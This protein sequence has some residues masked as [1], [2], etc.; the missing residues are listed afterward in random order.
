MTLIDEVGMNSHVQQIFS[1]AL[2]RPV[3]PGD[4]VELPIDL[5]LTHDVLGPP[6]FQI[7][8]KMDRAV[9][10]PEKVFLT[11]DHFVPAS[12]LEQAA[13]NAALVRYADAH[14]IK[15]RAFYDGP[16]HQTLA[17]SGLL[18]PG[19]VVVGTDS[20][21]CTAGAFGTFAMGIGCTEMAAVLAQGSTWFRVPHALQVAL[22]G[23]MRPLVMAKDIMLHLLGALGSD[24]ANG[25]SLEYSGPAL[26]HLTMDQRF[27][28]TNMGIEL[29]TMSAICPDDAILRH[30]V[31]GDF[32]PDQLLSEPTESDLVVDLGELEPLCATP[33]RPDNVVSIGSIA[34]SVPVQ[35]AFIG[36]CTGGRIDDFRA[37]ADLLAGRKV[38]PDVRLIIVPASKRIYRELLRSGMMEVFLDAGAIVEAA[39]CGPCAGLLGGVL[40]DGEVAI[41]ASSRNFRGRMGNPRSEIYLASPASVAAAAL[42]GEI[43][44]PRTVFDGVQLRGTTA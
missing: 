10:D 19:Q 28:L 42:A 33:H 7:L 8:E 15:H 40:A 35:E 43:V 18:R 39:S 36:S 31:Y 20:H 12:S 21:T 44:D 23:E 27:V 16:S 32:A 4:V 3:C 24:G 13:N 34:R 2:A 1:S 22:T 5:C 9:W 6:T 41:S 38:S 30:Y 14:A 26:E 29:G 25:A 37:A 11:I 17:E